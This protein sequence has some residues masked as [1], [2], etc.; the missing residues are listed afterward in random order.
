MTASQQIQERALRKLNEGSAPTIEQARVSIREEDPVLAEREREEQRREPRT[1]REPQRPPARLP[2]GP[3]GREMDAA[4][5]RLMEMNPDKYPTLEQ[6]KWRA[7]EVAPDLKLRVWNETQVVPWNVKTRIVRRA[8]EEEGVVDKLRGEQTEAAIEG[9]ARQDALAAYVDSVVAIVQRK[10]DGGLDLEAAV[11]DVIRADLVAKFK[12][13]IKNAKP[14]AASSSS[15][16]VS[17]RQ[18]REAVIAHMRSGPEGHHLEP[19]L[20]HVMKAIAS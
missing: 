12:P 9:R 7:G 15:I 1:F 6:A 14:K 4:A 8:G 16:R 18:F 3:A 17:P 20:E 19:S 10:V 5:R 2:L 13:K 11:T